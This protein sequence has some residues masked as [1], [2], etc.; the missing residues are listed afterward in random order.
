MNEGGRGEG[1]AR[2]G[3]ELASRNA[4]E[5]LIDQRKDLVERVPAPGAEIGQQFGD[6]RCGAS[7]R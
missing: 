5:L 4:A 2:A 3:G 1:V 6:A 7:W